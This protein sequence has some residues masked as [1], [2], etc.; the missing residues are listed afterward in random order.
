MNHCRQTERVTRTDSA[1]SDT[2]RLQAFRTARSTESSPSKNTPHINTMTRRFDGDH[3]RLPEIGQIQSCGYM[4]AFEED[5]GCPSGMRIVG[6]SENMA[7]VPWIHASVP[8]SEILGKDLGCAFSVEHVDTVR[9]LVKRSKQAS[10]PRGDHMFP[11]ANR[12]TADILPL[13]PKGAVPQLETEQNNEVLTCTLAESNP[14]VYMLELEP[15]H[16][17]NSAGE[18][19]TP[20]LRQVMELLECLP[21]GANPT[22]STAALCDALAESMPAF[23]RLMVYRFALDG[24]GEVIHESVRPGIEAKGSFLNLRFPA[25]DIPPIGRQM[26]QL[27]GV[28]FIAD[29]SAPGVPICIS[30]KRLAALD[31]SKSALR[32]SSECHLQFLRNMGVKASMVVAIVVGGELWG[33]Y[34]FHSYTSAVHPSCEERMLVSTAVAVVESLILQS[35]R[36]E[37]ATTAL[38]LSRVL[39]KLSSYLRVN[40]FFSAE[41]GALLNILDVDTI[42][43]REHSQ[44]VIVYGNKEVSLTQ[45]ECTDLRNEDESSDTIMFRSLPGKGVAFFSVDSTCVAFLRGSVA[46]HVKWAGKPEELQHGGPRASFEAFMLT[47]AATFKSWEPATVDLLG[48]MRHGISSKLYADALPFRQ[49][50]TFAHVSHELRTPFHGVM[51]SLEMLEAGRGTMDEA[52]QENIIRSALRCGHSMM[53]TLD[54]ILEVAKVRNNRDVVHDRFTPSSPILMTVA[55]MSP[56]AAT[57]S[58]DLVADTG[59]ADNDVREVFGDT[60]RIRGVVQNLVNNAIK[61]TPTGGKVRVSLVALD[62][63]QEVAQWWAKEADRFGARVWM[64]TPA[65]G[66]F[67]VEGSPRRTKW[68]VYGVEDSGVGVR[69]SDLPHLVAAYRQISQGASKTYA[70]TGLGLHICKAYVDVMLGALGI[71]STFSDKADRGGGTL[72]AVVLPLQ[73]A[74]QGEAVQQVDVDEN[75]KAGAKAN[76]PRC[77]EV[78]SRTIA[79]LVVDDHTVN[80]KLMEHKI[81]QF[82]RPSAGDVQVFAATDG[83]MALEVNTALQST[84]HEGPILVGIF[85]DFHLPNVDGTECTRRIRT[86]EA[87]NGWPPITICGCT[88]D[89]TK[90]VREAFKDAGGDGVIGKPW[91]PGEV[92]RMC[93]D[94]VAKVLDAEPS[95]A[96]GD[97]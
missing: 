13:P 46:S 39:G 8:A 15:K 90:K 32:A 19:R 26:L 96:E 97:P 69:P 67:F 38:S 82:F 28:S 16:G 81:K 64:G 56:F 41:Y 63:L 29:T 91:H 44:S 75:K 62:S 47:A 70:G 93:N 40:D 79:F 94:M 25:R 89:L 55:A 14:G 95:G 43:L 23:D 86:L 61:F 20:G 92:E 3:E 10:K 78:G 71:A 76:I 35:E 77:R 34:N 54:D 7:E 2:K 42:I 83:L 74:M 24:S 72:F 11:R 48:M 57:E 84:R 6:A 36:E 51:G 65:A 18:E 85:M 49:Q 4:L 21:V 58:V 66:G 87:D 33:S 80:I 27:K 52:E 53:A 30:H 5:P 31:L 45:R 12:N 1:E 37:I 59:S 9:S 88:A 60:R 73:P 68:Y 17:P 22:T 50:E